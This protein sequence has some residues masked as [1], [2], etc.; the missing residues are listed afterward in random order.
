MEVRPYIN[1]VARFFTI[2][3]DKEDSFNVKSNSSFMAAGVI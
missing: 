3:N 2:E 1:P